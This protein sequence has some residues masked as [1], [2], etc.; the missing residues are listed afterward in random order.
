[1]EGEGQLLALE[2]AFVW[3]M[4]GRSFTFVSPVAYVS[5]GTWRGERGSGGQLCAFEMPAAGLDRA[6]LDLED[7]S[8]HGS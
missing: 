2:I 7:E 4:P 1:M 3:S 6:A 5:R 8:F